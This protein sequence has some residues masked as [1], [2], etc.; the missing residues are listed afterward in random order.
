[1]AFGQIPLQQSPFETVPTVEP[2]PNRFGMFASKRG[3]NYLV[4][5]TRLK[6]WFASLQSG[7][8]ALGWLSVDLPLHLKEGRLSLAWLCAQ[9]DAPTTSS[10]AADYLEV[11][12]LRLRLRKWRHI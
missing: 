5:L 1:L 10:D 3:D 6:P 2:T 7:L 12:D 11:V 4:W 9:Q 8:N